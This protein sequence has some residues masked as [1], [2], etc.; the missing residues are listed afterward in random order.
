M[1]TTVGMLLRNLLF[2]RMSFSITYLRRRKKLAF[3]VR[4]LTYIGNVPY[5]DFGWDIAYPEFLFVFL[6][7]FFHIRL[8][9]TVPRSN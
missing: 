7:L 1:A 8:S 4:I 9:R 3:A 2:V 6:R 5:S